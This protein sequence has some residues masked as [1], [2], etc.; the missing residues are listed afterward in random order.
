M[1]AAFSLTQP[2][3]WTLTVP[4][5][6]ELMSFNTNKHWRV[7][8]P[9]KREWRNAT[10]LLAQS[11]QLPTGLGRVRIDVELR[12]PRGGRRDA[13]NY[14]PYVVKP[15][16]DALGPGREYTVRQGARAGTTVVECGYGLIPDDTE[17]YLDGPYPKI[18]QVADQKRY[19]RG[20]AIVT[21]TDLSPTVVPTGAA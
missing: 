11:A 8:S 7:T 2:R 3:T 13:A 18:G 9:V 17:T 10:F 19:P 12:F 6:A 1:T 14:H 21:I 4:A 16:V 15:I 5:P 20:L